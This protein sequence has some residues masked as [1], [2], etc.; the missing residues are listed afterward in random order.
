MTRFGTGS[1]AGI[2]F[3]YGLAPE[4]QLDVWVP[5]ALTSPLRGPT[6]VNLGNI[7]VALKYRFLHQRVSG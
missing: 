2:D 3:N 7:Q 4:T 5:A 1:S 6:A